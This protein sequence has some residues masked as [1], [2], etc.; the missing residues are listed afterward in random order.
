MD[1]PNMKKPLGVFSL[2][3]INVIAVDSLRTLPISAHYG[4]SIIFYYLLAAITFFIP[5]ALVTAEL[6]TGWPTKGGI[7]AWVK[8]AFG[9]K[10]GFLIIWLQWIYNIVWYPTILS[11]VAVTIAYLINPEL[12]QNKLYLV[13]T[14]FGLFWLSTLVNCF[15]MKTSSLISSF[16]A[17]VGTLIPMTFIILLSAYWLLSGHD[18]EII[19]SNYAWIPDLGDINNIVFFTAILFGLIGLEMSAV[20]VTEVGNPK[21]DYPRAL[22]ISSVIILITLTFASLAIAIAI[23]N[24]DIHIVSGVMDAFVAF[25]DKFNLAWM[26]PIIALLII[27]GSFSCVAAWIIG[28]TKGLLSASEDNPVLHFLRHTNNHGVPIR[29]LLAQGAV[30][31]ILCLVFL[32]M[33]SIQT[34]Y[35][36]LTVMTAQLALLVYV[37]MFAA[38]IKLHLSRPH[39]ERSFKIPGKNL[40]M[41]IVAGTGLLTCIFAIGLGFFPPEQIDIK[42]LWL[43][44]VTLIGGM[45][46]LCLPPIIISH[47][48]FHKE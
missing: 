32:L 20:H 13:F 5:A 22:L 41:F 9:A 28:P 48:R 44:E 6:A 12:A 11:F 3:M 47:K 46:I 10:V 21:R 25:F 39:V 33:P 7:Y 42:H 37:G 43:Y 30:F 18:A 1:L 19:F 34:A 38:A 8:E 36:L 24:E 45:A 31:T 23:P 2:V 16:G 17:V 26:T 35:W 29:I 14:T 27:F 40:G 15:G 4:S